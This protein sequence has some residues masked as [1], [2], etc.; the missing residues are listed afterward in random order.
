MDAAST[1]QRLRAALGPGR[2]VVLAAPAGAGKTAAVLELYLS[3]LDGVG[4]PGCLLVLPNS[5]TVAHLRS[6]LARR[7]RGGVLISP[8]VTTFGA[9][10]AAILHG[11][12]RAARPLS[13]P[14]RHLLILGIVQELARTGQLRALA[15]LADTPGLILALDATIA[16][17]KRSAVEPDDLAQAVDPHSDKDADLVAIYR[18]Y[19]ETLQASG[20]FDAEGLLW[21]ARN[22]L[23]G[24]AGAE[25]SEQPKSHGHAEQQRDRGTQPVQW[26]LGPISRVAVDGFVDFTPTQLDVLSLLAARLTGGLAV[27]LPLA[28]EPAR[29]RM[30]FWTA[31]T[32]ARITR[33]IPGAQVLQLPGPDLLPGLFDLAAPPSRKIGDSIPISGKDQPVSDRSSNGN[34]YT[35]PDFP[36]FPAGARASLPALLILEA[37]DL[38]SEVRAVARAVKADLLAGAGRIG[39]V[40]RTLGEYD[41]PIRRI[42]GQYDVPVA[43]AAGGLA[44]ASVVRHVLRLLSLPDEYAFHDLLAVLRSSYFR[45][46]AL[47]DFGPPDV[48]TAEMAIRA[49]S[50]AGGRAA[51]APAMNL[52]ARRAARAAEGGDEEDRDRLGPLLKDAVAIERASRLVEALLARLDELAACRQSGAYAQCVGRLLAALELEAAVLSADDDA[53]VA[54]DLRALRALRQLLDDVAAADLAG[55]ASELAA[56]T[57]RLCAAAEPEPARREALATVLDA[58]DARAL[59]FDRLYLL[60][61][62]ERSFP[63]LRQDTCFISEADRAD[64]AQRGIQL[65]RRSDLIGR[66]MLLFYLACTRTDWTGGTAANDAAVAPRLGMAPA[67]RLTIS[68]LTG[69]AVGK[70]NTR[71]GFVDELVSAAERLGVAA[72]TIHLEPGRFVPPPA[73]IA[74]AD[75]ALA[76]ALSAAFDTEPTAQQ[77]APALLDWAARHQPAAL[78]R[79]AAGIFAAR[80]RWRRGVVDAFDGRIDQPALL[81]ELGRLFDQHVFSASQINGYARCPWHFFARYLL[82]LEELAEPSEQLAPAVRGS[83][84]HAVLCRVM[85]KLRERAGGPVD[86]SKLKPEELDAELAA[87][88]EAQAAAL[89]AD[90]VLLAQV[91]CWRSLLR[92]YLSA[93]AEQMGQWGDVRAAWFELGFGDRGSRR[94]PAS[95]KEPVTL[96]LPG[97]RIRLA[98]RIDRVDLLGPPDAQRLL[99]VDYKT[100]GVPGRGDIEQHRDLQLALY[101]AAL[102][103]LLGRPCAGGVY[104]GLADGS[105]RYFADTLVSRGKRT[106]DEEFPAK[107]DQALAAA[108]GLV[109]GM[110][111]GRFDALPADECIRLCPYRQVC[112]YS[113][114]RAEVKRSTGVPPVNVHGQD[115]RATP[116]AHATPEA[117]HE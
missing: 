88:V 39:V 99:A 5:P 98:G 107:L 18:R 113:P 91:A 49:A 52:V 22:E 83:F 77:A 4:R 50:V 7:C 65:D 76:A 100:G 87:A 26:G 1:T 57:A 84:C 109:A 48:R 95:L 79:A 3:S 92:R 6:E 56:L 44:Q 105:Q 14:Q 97:C 114:V 90:P 63:Q 60:G 106:S 117:D 103:E 69:D 43:D 40:A 13:K 29:R 72:T 112:H 70:A 12:G 55:T 74:S 73:E 80:R 62:N 38:E 111:A 16:E 94:D 75:E 41:E 61:A 71:S 27:T 34:R 31:R 2:T 68:Y 93:Q 64:W 67:G 33:R 10:A 116:D 86:L 108:A 54:A 89:D 58:L 78:E 102:G 82:R 30:W 24:G 20:R 17:L 51:Y 115:A 110:R 104:H 11:A 59:R 45:P 46:R 19:Q 85:T 8:A 23:L 47:G 36:D 101:T 32:L 53:V 96:G 25:S 9:L 37:P 35:V 28:D 21:L 42:F 81:A 15:G 66:E